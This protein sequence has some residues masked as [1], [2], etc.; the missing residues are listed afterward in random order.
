MSVLIALITIYGFGRNIA[1]KLV[2]PPVARPLVLYLHAALFTGW[3]AFFIVQSALVGSGNVRLHRITGCFGAVIGAGV[4]VVGIWTAITMARFNVQHFHSR[5][6]QASLLVSLYDISAFAVPF[7]LAIYWRRKPELHRRLMLISMCALMAAA[8]GRFP[9]PPHV[10]AL[11]FF[12]AG[13]DLLL[14]L[15]IARDLTLTKRAHPVYLYGLAAF[16][17]CQLAVARA[18]YHHSTHWQRIARG[19]LG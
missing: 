16:A 19:I 9:I 12:Y 4:L 14:V 18:I 15:G 7:A 6:P 13:V 11:T 8:I 5:Y 17:V 2:H 1:D 10:R 3:V